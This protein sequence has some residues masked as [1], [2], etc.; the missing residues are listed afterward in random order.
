MSSETKDQDE[1]LDTGNPDQIYEYRMCPGFTAEERHG[2]ERRLVEA[3]EVV[4]RT[5]EFGHTWGSR[6]Q[7]KVRGRWVTPPW[8]QQ[9]AMQIMRDRA[10]K[11]PKNRAQP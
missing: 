1:A 10:L 3:G 2:S 8:S 4:K 6:C 11:S 9:D 7:V 5:R